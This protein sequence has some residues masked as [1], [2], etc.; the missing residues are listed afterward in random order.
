MPAEERA[1]DSPA[2]EETPTNRSVIRLS[3]QAA[4]AFDEALAQPRA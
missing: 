2:D 1:T 3:P 4:Q